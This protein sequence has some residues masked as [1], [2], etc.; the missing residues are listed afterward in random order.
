MA[1]YKD[2]KVQVT[3]NYS[4]FRQLHGN[5]PVDE[6]RVKKV[7]KSIAQV[8]QLVPIIINDN[9]EVVDGQA[10]LEALKRLNMPVMYLK[11]A[12]LTR[13]EC[14]EMNNTQSR[15]NTGAYIS[16]FA[17]TGNV[18]YMYLKSLFVEYKDIPAGAIYAAATGTYNNS[19]TCSGIT[20]GTFKMTVK[21]YE[22]ARRELNYCA[23]CH[24]ALRDQPGRAQYYLI[25]AIFCF[26]SPSIDNSRLVHA[27]NTRSAELLPATSV[28]IATQQLE[29]I[30]NFKLSKKV[31]I[32]S[33]YRQEIDARVYVGNKARKI[34]ITEAGNA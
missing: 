13:N 4:V 28:D 31:Y 20:K 3:N 14:V 26:R 33:L 19:A 10:R 23:K 24:P 16:S 17:D 1:N 34:K 30:Y 18:S 11:V 27:L 8:G 9:N 25:A 32:N 21:D 2:A 29:K 22:R 7:Q 12:G 6:Y 15:W 5:R